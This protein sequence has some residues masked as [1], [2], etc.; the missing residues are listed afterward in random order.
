MA[1]VDSYDDS[2]ADPIT[3]INNRET[4]NS[5]INNSGFNLESNV[6]NKNE[7]CLNIGR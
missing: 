4:K 1:I 3:W 5:K 2:D 7:L 6:T